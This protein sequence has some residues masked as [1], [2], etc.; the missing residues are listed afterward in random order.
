MDLSAGAAIREHTWVVDGACCCQSAAA[1][2]LRRLLLPRR[3]FLLFSHL[4]TFRTGM[5][6][7]ELALLL[8]YLSSIYAASSPG[9]QPS[10]AAFVSMT[11]TGTVDLS[12][13]AAIRENPG[14]AAGACCRQCCCCCCCFDDDGPW[15][16]AF[17]HILYWYDRF[18]NTVTTSGGMRFASHCMP[19]YE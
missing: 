5:I 15:I 3:L 2:M 13:G 10:S 8:L 11:T 9:K 7:P 6:F 12:A 4:E 17:G 18:I 1:A 14:S 16:F 19:W